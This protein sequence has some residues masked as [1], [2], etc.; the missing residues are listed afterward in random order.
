M[1]D[2]GQ[3]GTHISRSVSPQSGENVIGPKHRGILEDYGNSL[4]LD[5]NMGNIK[6]YICENSFNSIPKSVYFITYKLCFHKVGV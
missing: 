2:K 6:V 4:Y 3:D 1:K 5:H